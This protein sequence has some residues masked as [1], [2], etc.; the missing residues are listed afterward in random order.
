MS[1]KQSKTVPEGNG[2][3]PHHDEFG[4]DKLTMADLY[5]ML[6]KNFDRIKGTWI[7]WKLA[8]TDGWANLLRRRERQISV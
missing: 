4:S 3:V 5:Q 8:S 6:E 1:R 2:P 7:G